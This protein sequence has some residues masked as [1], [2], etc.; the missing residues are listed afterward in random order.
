VIFAGETRL[1]YWSEDA[2]ER[3]SSELGQGVQADPG[4]AQG[5]SD[6]VLLR[7]T[8]VGA[9]AARQV[10]PVRLQLPQG[11][12][13]IFAEAQDQETKN[14]STRELPLYSAQRLYLTLLLYILSIFLFK[15]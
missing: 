11:V 13:L 5:Q 2:D 4:P 12:L 7:S 8:A 3:R 14:S 15:F 1:D 6:R 9:H 10:R